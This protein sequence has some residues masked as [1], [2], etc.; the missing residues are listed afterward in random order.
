M[1]LRVLFVCSGPAMYRSS[2]EYEFDGLDDIKQSLPSDIY[3]YVIKNDLVKYDLKF[4]P[5][6]EYPHILRRSLPVSYV[7]RLTRE[8][9][10]KIEYR[11]LDKYREYI[12][13]ELKS[14]YPDLIHIDYISIDPI[15]LD[16][17]IYGDETVLELIKEHD[18]KYLDSYGVSMKFIDHYTMNFQ[19]YIHNTTD[20]FDVIWFLQCSDFSNVITISQSY[21]SD[22]K[23]ILEKDYL[24]IHMDWDGTKKIDP[25][26]GFNQPVGKITPIYERFARLPSTYY[27]GK[28]EKQKIQWFL[29]HLIQIRPGI[30]QFKILKKSDMVSMLLL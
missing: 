11:D 8:L 24:I 30:Y 3:D 28:N 23:K 2:Y 26:T 20:K 6:M 10:P 13:K 16:P 29:N 21:I 18:N 22:F 19:K 15:T 1:S 12:I 25:K 17:K 5:E 4:D 9:D 7:Q 14:I 27:S